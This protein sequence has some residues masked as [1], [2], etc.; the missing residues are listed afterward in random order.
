M[1]PCEYC[2]YAGPTRSALTQ[3]ILRAKRSK[4][5]H[6]GEGDSAP[7]SYVCSECE[8]GFTTNE[9]L[10]VHL[11]RTRHAG[12]R[13]Y[14][15]D[16]C[17]RDDFLTRASQKGHRYRCQQTQD[18]RCEHCEYQ[19]NAR[20]NLVRH[21]A[22]CG[23]TERTFICKL[24]LTEE[25]NEDFTLAKR[26]LPAAV[27]GARAAVAADVVAVGSFAVRIC[28]ASFKT[29]E[30]LRRHKASHQ[31][32][33][34]IQ[35]SQCAFVAD[36][37]TQ[38]RN[39]RTTKHKKTPTVW[40]YCDEVD[41]YYK[42][43]SAPKLADHANVHTGEKPY[44]CEVPGC[45]FSCANSGAF[46]NHRLRHEPAAQAKYPC[47]HCPASYA[48]KQDLDW[49]TERAHGSDGA[50]PGER[51]IAEILAKF[52]AP[53][54][55]QAAPKFLWAD[56]V[57]PVE[58][59]QTGDDRLS[60]DFLI[61]ADSGW[62]LAIEYD[63]LAHHKPYHLGDT[64]NWNFYTQKTRDLRKSRLAESAGVPLLRLTG[65][66]WSQIETTLRCVLSGSLP[67]PCP[68]CAITMTFAQ[69]MFDH[70]ETLDLDLPSGDE[71]LTKTRELLTGFVSHVP[72]NLESLSD[73]KL[74]YVTEA[75][76]LIHM[77][78]N[79]R[80][81]EPWVV[82]LFKSVRGSAPRLRDLLKATG[83]PGISLRAP[84]KH[85]PRVVGN[86]APS[87]TVAGDIVAMPGP[88]IVP[89]V[90]TVSMISCPYPG[91]TF[92]GGGPVKF[93][94]T[95][96]TNERFIEHYNRDHGLGLKYRC[97]DCEECFDNNKLRRAHARSVHGQT[98]S[99]QIQKLRCGNC[100]GAE[101]WTS[102]THHKRHLLRDH[103]LDVMNLPNTLPGHVMSGGSL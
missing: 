18:L 87:P 38:L 3:H 74:R 68:P 93:S 49:H 46:Y 6:G 91:C 36:N 55:A 1:F 90:P 40:I 28:G 70:V 56:F 48:F 15:C 52:G 89:A 60:Y 8:L 57:Q 98:A 69:A 7:P 23:V 37:P 50:S 79:Q 61:V 80:K 64:P 4:R 58:T 77:I 101:I 99:G 96:K 21:Q 62:R 41:C 66:N 30:D 25:E 24:E 92:G 9:K 67:E 34:A 65:T 63:G 12:C 2:T 53:T 5:G 20:A 17:G 43:T 102:T 59:R 35:C 10:Q 29:A 95:G 85:E 45:E 33:M 22:R 86:V 14:S 73:D 19:T 103:G 44:L 81:C 54:I 100:P 72:E 26:R 32:G 27:A 42:T 94:R 97:T 47:G 11:D 75:A 13:T 83:A 51:K 88:A 84:A 82:A 16:R 76:S 71:I 78:E 31:R 39:H